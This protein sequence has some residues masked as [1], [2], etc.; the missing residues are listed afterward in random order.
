MTGLLLTTFESSKGAS[1]AIVFALSRRFDLQVVAD[2]FTRANPLYVL[3]ALLANLLSVAAKAVTWKAAFDAIPG[4]DGEPPVEVGMRDVVPAIFIAS[5]VALL[6]NA[7]ID[8]SSRIATLGV[9]VGI[10]LGL[11][12]YSFITRRMGSSSSA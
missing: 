5:T 1:A 2:V 10:A 6:L 7:L 3:A 11:P 9:F 4:E 8:R 12:I